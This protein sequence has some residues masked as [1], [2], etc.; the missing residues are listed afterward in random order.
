MKVEILT[1]NFNIYIC[2][3]RN[4]DHKNIGTMYDADRPTS[5]IKGVFQESKELW[6][7]ALA[8]KRVL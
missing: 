4:T 6:T 8:D 5:K 7:E 1:L 2:T 3:S